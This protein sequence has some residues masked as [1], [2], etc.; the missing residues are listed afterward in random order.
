MMALTR[1]PRLSL[2]NA[3]L[4]VEQVGSAAAVVEHRRELRDLLP[5][6]TDR[7]TEAMGGLD[8][9]LE[10]A[11]REYD[12]ATAG[13]IRCLSLGD[14]DYPQQLL[15][16]ED[17]PLVLYY[18]GNSDL[19]QL[20]VV[21]IVGTRR[22]TSY[23]KDVCE[24]F[25]A[26]LQRYY[27][28]TLIVSGL[29]YGVDIT[30]HRAALSHGMATVGVL[31]H[32]LDTIYPS[33]HRPTAAMMV[34]QGGLLTEYMSKTTPEK[35]NFVRRNRIVAGLACAT[36]VV[37]S[38][39]RGGSLITADL[40]A[41]YNREVC[42]FPGRVTDQY[43]EGC[44]QLIAQQKAHL[45]TSAEDFLHA[46]GWP[47]PLKGKKRSRQQELFPGEIPLTPDEQA[48]VTTLVNVDD[49]AINQIVVESNLPYSRVSALL[50]E[51]EM[52]NLV[53][54]LGGARYRL[55]IVKS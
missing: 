37:E 42:T 43:S 15:Q 23:G 51:M 1:L 41:T 25:V 28:D 29:A 50:F 20:H 16:C 11:K 32:G 4:L 12:F 2:I 7:L 48:I 35:G 39:A 49:K 10:Q 5:E 34:K 52:K 54:A 40:A 44:N 46:V 45:I 24:S 21:S 22:C 13:H 55:K 19:N 36:V 17:A 8:D 47:D 3:R 9:A 31:A 26:D 27:P 33:L 18:L 14:A 6:A 30:A 38:G 53:Q